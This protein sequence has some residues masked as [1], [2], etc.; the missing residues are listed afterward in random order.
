[1][2]ALS[3]NAKQVLGVPTSCFLREKGWDHAFMQHLVVAVNE[4]I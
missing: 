2:L 4:K 3:A 1:M